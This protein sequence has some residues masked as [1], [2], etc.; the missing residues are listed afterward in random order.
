MQIC[1]HWKDNSPKPVNHRLTLKERPKVKSDKMRRFPANDI[2]QVG[3]TLQ[4]SR[5]NNNRV[6]RIFQINCPRLTLK[7]VFKVKSDPIRRF[8]AHDFL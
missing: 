2:L 3:F 1:I 6:I 4:T 7:E 5:T 8:A